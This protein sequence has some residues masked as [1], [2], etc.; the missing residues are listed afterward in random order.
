MRRVRAVVLN[1]RTDVCLSSCVFL[2]AGG[3]NRIIRGTI[4]IHRPFGTQTGGKD[5][6][7]AQR[8]YRELQLLIRTFFQE[9]NVSAALYDTMLGV[10]PETIRVLSERELIGFGLEGLDPVEQEVQDSYE[11]QKYGVSRAEY[12]RRKT[13]ADQ[14]CNNVFL[15]SGQFAAYFECDMRIKVTGK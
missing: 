14:V 10:P 9:M 4:G 6:E 5:Y 13:L 15:Q 2:L 11:S 8:E 1:G 3:T 7:S 12:L